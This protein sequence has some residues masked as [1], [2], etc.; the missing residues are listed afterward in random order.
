[1]VDSSMGVADNV[2]VQSCMNQ[3]LPN[4]EEEAQK[5]M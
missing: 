4:L 1:M 3:F 5:Q 2:E